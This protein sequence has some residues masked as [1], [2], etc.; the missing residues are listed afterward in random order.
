VTIGHGLFAALGTAAV[1]LTAWLRTIIW[2]T[3]ASSGF[4]ARCSRSKSSA[5]RASWPTRC[6]PARD[7]GEPG[8]L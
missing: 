5:Q 7:A 2:A 4:A 3:R 8:P 6:A 1:A